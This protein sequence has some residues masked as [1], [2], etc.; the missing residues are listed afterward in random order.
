MS[1]AHRSSV[2]R[3]GLDKIRSGVLERTLFSSRGRRADPSPARF[4]RHA[5]PPDRGVA[6]PGSAGTAAARHFAAPD[7]RGWPPTSA[8]RAGS[9]SRPT[10]SCSPRATDRR[11][12]GDAGGQ[13]SR[14]CGAAVAEAPRRARLPP[15]LSRPI[16]VP[17]RGLAALDAAGGRD[18]ARHAVRLPEP[19]GAPARRGARRRTS[20]ACAARR[21]GRTNIVICNGYAQGIALVGAV[22]ARRGGEAD[23]ARGSGRRRRGRRPAAGL[24]VA[25]V[26][27]DEGRHPRR[28]AR[29]RGR[30]A[31]R[32]H[33]RPPV[34]HRR[35]ALGRAPGRVLAL[36]ERRGALRH[37][38]RLRRGVPLRP[39][40][41]GAMQGL[42]R[43]G[44]L[45]G[46]GEQD[47]RARAAPGLARRP[48][49][50]S[51]TSPPAKSLADR[52]SP[53]LEQL[54]FADFLARGE[55]DRHLRRMR[56]LYRRRRDALVAALALHTARARAG[57]DRRRPAP[58]RL[59]AEDQRRGGGRP[60]RRPARP[61][62]STCWRRTASTARAA[63]A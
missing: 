24:D 27:V 25:G 60:G 46:H 62:R 3:I 32:P 15:R 58:R 57:R 35:G 8:S 56:A 9:S 59:P 41:V 34:A 48:P 36:G 50:S 53:V 22:L 43:T 47:A 10:S 61:R 18:G 5:A 21:R 2:P 13:P 37:R 54:A 11:A 31:P 1:L 38:G 19:H 6:P 4:L 45:R 55:Y 30:R 28:R 40:A 63:R 16:A 29:A 17:A 52:G 42:P 39:G 44:R 7:A 26:P 51:T 49:P 23:R 14:D 20:T 33:A 12:G